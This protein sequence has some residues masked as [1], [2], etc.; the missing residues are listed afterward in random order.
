MAIVVNDVLQFSISGTFLGQ[1][2]MNVFH[3]GVGATDGTETL[4]ELMAQWT[5]EYIADVTPIM[6]AQVQIQY[7]DGKN[8]SNGIDIATA[9]PSSVFGQSAGDVLPA[10]VAWSFRLNR[11]TA[12]TRH[13][14]KRIPGVTELRQT[15]GVVNADFLTQI[16]TVTSFLAEAFDV[17]GT[18][19]API[20]VR[21]FPQEHAQAGELDLTGINPVISAAYL[22]IST[23]NTR[24][25]GRGI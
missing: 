11:M 21:R 14:H 5:L 18:T 24:K 7:V 3:Y 15:N 9:T 10:F 25:P 1:R 22:G 13:G 6:S 23:Q 2:W 17:N 20:I 12:L 8:L 4:D 19:I 16:G